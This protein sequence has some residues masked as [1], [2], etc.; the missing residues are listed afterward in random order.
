MTEQ[1]DSFDPQQ[2]IP[3]QEQPTKIPQTDDAAA[4]NKLK[5]TKLKVKLHIYITKTIAIV[6]MVQGIRNIGLEVY[7]ILFQI[8]QLSSQ[9]AQ[10]GFSMDLYQQIW[11]SAFII[12]ISSLI[13]A[14]YGLIMLF[15]PNGAVKVINQLIGIALIIITFL[16]SH[17]YINL[18][19]TLSSIGV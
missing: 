18:N 3:T 1:Q 12:S 9:I 15:K 7:K 17:N 8:P 4:I 16:I 10:S 13:N 2:Y 14:S 6:M 11:V 5:Y 19:Q